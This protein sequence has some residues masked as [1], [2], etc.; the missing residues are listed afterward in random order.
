MAFQIRLLGELQLSDRGGRPKALPASK[1]TRALIG[2]LV[3]TGIPHRRERLCDLLWEG[4]DDPR[5]ELRWSLNKIRPLLNEPGVTRISADRERIGFEACN[6]EVDVVRVRELLA[7]DISA[8][9]V[10]ELET[11][12]GLLRGELLDGLDLPACYRYQEWCLA[13]REAVSRLRLAALSALVQLLEGSPDHA[14]IHARALVVADPLSEAGHATVVR[15]LGRLGRRREALEHSDYARRLLETELGATIS[16]EIERARRALGP[17]TSRRSTAQP[18]SRPPAAP[19]APVRS[20]DENLPFVGRHDECALLDSMAAIADSGQGRHVLLIKG[21]A[22]IGKSRLLARLR[23][24]MSALG[25]RAFDGRAYEAELSRP[26]AIWIDLLRALARERGQDD[27][28]DLA[29]LL[30]ELARI[31]AGPPTSR[32]CSMRS[33]ICCAS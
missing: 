30:P 11:A 17:A 16:G 29:P 1:K 21:E 15:L 22:G 32:N 9:S 25:G 27:L 4:P 19:A 6:A 33:S 10:E 7:G 23:E 26:Y 8:R 24:R 12:I 31:K 14:L 18:S 3:A 13:E 28:S 20:T 5:A 2:Y